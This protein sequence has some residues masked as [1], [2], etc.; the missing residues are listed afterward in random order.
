MYVNSCLDKEILISWLIVGILA[1]VLVAGVSPEWL[2]II[3]EYTNYCTH[4]THYG[5][6]TRRR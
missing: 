1:A 5:N 3:H 4:I 2:V 6:Q